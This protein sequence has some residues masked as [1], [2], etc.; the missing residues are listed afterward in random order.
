MI[1]KR[2]TTALFL[3]F[4]FNV[5]IIVSQLVL[6]IKID[7]L[8]DFANPKSQMLIQKLIF[9]HVIFFFYNS[10]N[11]PRNLKSHQRLLQ[12]YCFDITR[13]MQSD[14]KNSECN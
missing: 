4:Q 10:D 12:N 5:L 7:C 6:S 1:L 13:V 3:F 11:I 9:Y 14:M 2:N 8:P